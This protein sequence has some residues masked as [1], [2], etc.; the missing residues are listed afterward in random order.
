MNMWK[1]GESCT[2]HINILQF[3]F[4][5][6]VFF[7]ESIYLLLNGDSFFWVINV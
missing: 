4:S 3:F 5:V 2:T 6:K 7:A 1:N